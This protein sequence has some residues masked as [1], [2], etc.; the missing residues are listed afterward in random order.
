MLETCTSEK[1]RPPFPHR[2]GRPLPNRGL[3]VGDEAQQH[4]H[5]A[6][7]QHSSSSSIAAQ[8]TLKHTHTHR[9]IYAYKCIFLVLANVFRHKYQ[10]DSQCQA[11][12][13]LIIV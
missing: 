4:T 12:Y 1:T 7:T 3:G 11:Y 8:H 5:T 2:L 6:A 10:V 13:M 9:H